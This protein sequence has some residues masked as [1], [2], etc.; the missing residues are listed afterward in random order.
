VSPPWLLTR[1]RPVV[2]WVRTPHDDNTV[3]V[4]LRIRFWSWATYCTGFEVTVYPSDVKW[5]SLC[6]YTFQPWGLSM[7]SSSGTP[8]FTYKTTRCHR[9]EDNNQNYY[10]FAAY[11]L[12]Y[13]CILY[14]VVKCLHVCANVSNVITPGSMLYWAVFPSHSC[15][16]IFISAYFSYA[17]WLQLEATHHSTVPTLCRIH[18]QAI[19]R[20]NKILVYELCDW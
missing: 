12:L 11:V 15:P 6:A 14:F 5:L 2:S 8:V 18:S 1:D 3:T 19:R 13:I 17:P 4:Q 9:T 10:T 7:P 20:A 16:Q